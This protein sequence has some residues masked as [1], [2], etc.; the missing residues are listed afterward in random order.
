MVSNMEKKINLTSKQQ[1]AISEIDHNLQ[2]IACA[3]SGKTE[4]ITRRIANIL[5][6]KQDIKPENIVAFTF[7][8]KAAES[9]ENRI[10]RALGSEL[11][12][13]IKRVW[14]KIKIAH[15]TFFK[16]PLHK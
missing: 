9:L 10:V 16:V 14:L 12:A 1:E 15:S 8:N 11:S 13:N 6:S 4:V 7:T 3:G 5:H 2:I